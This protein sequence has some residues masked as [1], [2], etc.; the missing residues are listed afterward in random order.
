MTADFVQQM[1]RFILRHAMI[2][3]GETVL[4]AVSGGADSLALLY[5]LHALHSQLNC[6]LHVAHLNHCLR[7]DADADADFVRQHAAHLGVPCTLQKAEVSHLGK[8]WKLSIEAAARRARY[9]FFEEVCER[10]GATKV[11]LGHHQDDTAETVLMN[12]LR[13]SGSAGM[14]GI[15][16]VRNFKFIRPLTGFTRQ[17]I[18]TFLASKGLVPRHDATNTDTRYLRNRIRHELIPRLESDYN[19]NI[20]LGLSRTADVLNAESEYLDTVAREAFEICR[21]RDS[22]SVKALTTSE[23]IVLDREKFQQ[24][25][26]A[27][28]RRVLRLSFFEILGSIGDLYFSHCEAMLRLIEGSAPNA[29]LALPNSLRFQRVYQH[30]IFEVNINSRSPFPIESFAYPLVVPGKTFIAALNTEITAELGEIR[31]GETL[32]IPDGRYEA[33]FDYEKVIGAFAT[34]SSETPRLAVRNRRQGDRFQP[35]GMRGTKK[36][37][38]FMID[39]KVPRYERDRTPMLVRGNQVLWV[40]GYTTSD[41]FKIHSGTRQYL[42][43]RYAS[44]KT[45]S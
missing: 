32:T 21:I 23:N 27:V 8:Q 2:K 34:V 24:F 9:Q 20:K 26:I 22:D 5:S 37:K 41:P 18:E 43:L 39:A 10:I 25:H 3:N 14:K 17:Q 35:Y 16:P 40:V 38:D 29:A 30:L 36:I 15:P 44:D 4:V 7:P 31:S 19:P 28:Q 33:F 6:Q 13:G 42:Y 1:H 12:L 45:V 11:A